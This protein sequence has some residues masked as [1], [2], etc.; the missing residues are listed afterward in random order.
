MSANSPK[1]SIGSCRTLPDTGFRRD[2]LTIYAY[3]LLLAYVWA[4]Y[5][6]GPALLMLREELGYTRTIGSLHSVA[7]S[8]G[9]ITVGFVGAR[10]TK[11]IGRS[12]SVE[13]GT[14]GV[15]VGVLLL[16]YAP[17]PWLSI[18]G[19]F[20]IGF[21]GSMLTNPMNAFLTLHHHRHGPRAIAESNAGA[22]FAGL[23]APLLIGGLVALQLDWRF[24]LLAGLAVLL[25]GT[26]M[27]GDATALEI[28]EPPHEHSGTR[29]P[30]LYWR[31]W[32]ALA[33]CIGAEFSF[34]LWS[35]DLLRDRAQVSTAVA[36]AGLSAVAVGMTISRI[37]SSRL[38]KHYS[39]QQLFVGATVLALVMWFPLWF[40]TSA[41]IML[42]SMLVIG[43]GLGAHFPLGMSRLLK[44]APGM[45]EEAAARSSLAAG[46]AGAIMPF[47]LGVIGDAVGIHAAFVAVP[48]LFVVALITAVRN[49]VAD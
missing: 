32:F 11:A 43:L 20:L 39:M 8:F 46:L 37:A 26:A 9:I 5:S 41:P 21:G 47:A 35:G 48:L 18:P 10:V 3:I 22:A 7:L 4:L 30:T 15:A 45:V 33:L 19:G 12:R 31:N 6:V 27:R 25:V 36:A 14:V 23:A 1:Q 17:T 49:P 40:S 34:M 29:L 42:A 16:S 38:L 2:R 44:S 24:A 13:I 28:V